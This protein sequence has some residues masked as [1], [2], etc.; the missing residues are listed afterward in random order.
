MC[1][2]SLRNRNDL[3]FL[4]L[5]IEALPLY[6]VLSQA[7]QNRVFEPAPKNTRKIIVSTNIAETGLTIPGIRYVV[8]SGL[9]KERSVITSASGSE[10]RVPASPQRL[11]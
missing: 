1:W 7:Q 10:C 3:K 2:S 6:R 11:Y 8:D 4:L 5:K 9:Q